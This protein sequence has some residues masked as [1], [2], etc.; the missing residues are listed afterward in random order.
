MREI[1]QNDVQTSDV[2]YISLIATATPLQACL[3][4]TSKIGNEY[5]HVYAERR[6]K[7]ILVDMPGYG[8]AYAQ[9]AHREDW[10]GLVKL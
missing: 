2:Q 1:A 7:L 6:A 4:I 10:K 3:I 5:G 8:F 9:E